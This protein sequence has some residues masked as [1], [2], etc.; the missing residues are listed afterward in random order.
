M[1]MAVTIVGEWEKIYG[2]KSELLF[3]S[4]ITRVIKST[5]H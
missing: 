5:V 1:M 4:T 2:E 3:A